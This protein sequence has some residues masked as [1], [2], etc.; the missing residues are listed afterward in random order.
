[1]I[2]Q[3]Y[4]MPFQQGVLRFTLLTFALLALW[5]APLIPAE[6]LPLLPRSGDSIHTLSLDAVYVSALLQQPGSVGAPP[7]GIWS[8]NFSSRN[9]ASFPMTITITQDT[10]GRLR[11]AATLSSQC[12]TE[13]TLVV[14]V[15]GS[16][17]SLAGSDSLGDNIT[18]RGTI[19]PGG[20]QLTL[21]YIANGSASGRCETD[22][23][24]GIAGKQ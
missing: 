19:D 1:V 5:T 12:I 20:A 14:T 2:S 8:G 9:F 3:E 4:T 7:V 6:A 10:T 24:T 15:S 21:S 17:I 11:G 23:G 18:F 22:Q 13:A 16:N